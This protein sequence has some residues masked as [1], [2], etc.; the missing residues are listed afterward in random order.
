MK[1]QRIFVQV[2]DQVNNRWK[3]YKSSNTYEEAELLLKDLQEKY[4]TAK[5]RILNNNL[6]THTY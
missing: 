2:Q 1:R 6:M 5:L 4:P 3:N